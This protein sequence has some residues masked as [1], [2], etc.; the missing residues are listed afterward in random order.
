MPRVLLNMLSQTFTHALHA[1]M[2]PLLFM[3]F[4]YEHV[5]MLKQ[6]LKYVSSCFVMNAIWFVFATIELIEHAFENAHA[7]VEMRFKLPLLYCLRL[8]GWSRQNLFSQPPRRPS[9]GNA[10]HA[11]LVWPNG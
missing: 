3:C 11:S 10:F 5:S 7:D 8:S 9:S 2:N 1:V 6:M 4:F